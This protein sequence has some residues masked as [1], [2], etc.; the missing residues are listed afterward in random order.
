MTDPLNSEEGKRRKEKGIKKV[1]THNQVWLTGATA[2]LLD[3]LRN[4]ET[5][6]A[7]DLRDYAKPKHP[8]CIGGVW[9]RMRRADLIR[10]V[11]YKQAE[12]TT[13]HARMIGEWRRF[14]PKIDKPTKQV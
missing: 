4:Q 8:N 9:N 2:H 14:D 12:A 3:K 6:S 7:D 11:R 1:L 13:A 10:L 5:V